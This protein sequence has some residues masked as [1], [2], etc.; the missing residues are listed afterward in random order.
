MKL[1]KKIINISLALALASTVFAESSYAEEVN[2]ENSPNTKIENEIKLKELTLLEENDDLENIKNYVSSL[3]EAIENRKDIE[4]SDDFNYSTDEVKKEYKELMDKINE[5]LSE[6]K[7]DKKSLEEDDSDEKYQNLDAENL[8]Q[9]LEDV[10]KAIE[11]INDNNEE[12]ANFDHTLNQKAKYNLL[13]VDYSL[14][15]EAEDLF[16]KFES[17]SKK[18][19]ED[20]S[21]KD[22]VENKNALESLYT[23][24]D[25][26][27]KT[28]TEEYDQLEELAKIAEKKGLDQANVDRINEYLTNENLTLQGIR[29]AKTL[30][31]N[32]LEAKE[33]E[34]KI[35]REK[36]EEYDKRLDDLSSKIEKNEAKFTDKEKADFK[37]KIEN[38]KNSDS[39]DENALKKLE[40]EA[41]KIIKRKPARL[42][43]VVKKSA[44]KKAKG[45]VR[46]GVQALTGVIILLVVAGL[47]FGFLSYKQR[48][49]DK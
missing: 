46:T 21:K 18:D 3:N 27:F 30:I 9:T 26:Y 29:D 6:N 49:K 22:L 8:K 17:F 4:K 41:D 36:R 39:M 11:N 28:R 20:K 7:L 44:T 40:E 15:K 43:K 38:L 10:D 5:F 31:N 13:Q 12:L 16:K 23:K 24:L 47:A 35:A 32:V 25:N 34:E 48:K 37:E 45:I 33:K 2:V 1:N 42:K 14:K 19:K